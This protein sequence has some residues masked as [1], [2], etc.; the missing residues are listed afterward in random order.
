MTETISTF[1]RARGRSPS[2]PSAR[3]SIVREKI[4]THVLGMLTSLYIAAMEDRHHYG[5]KAAHLMGLDEINIPRVVDRAQVKKVINGHTSQEVLLRTLEDLVGKAE[6]QNLAPGERGPTYR[7]FQRHILHMLYGST[8]PYRQAARD[9]G[10]HPSTIHQAEISA[11]PDYAPPLPLE[12]RT[13]ER[14]FQHAERMSAQLGHRNLLAV[15]ESLYINTILQMHEESAIGKKSRQVL[16]H[17]IDILRDRQQ[18]LGS[19]YHIPKGKSVRQTLRSALE[20]F[21]D[22]KMLDELMPKHEKH[23]LTYRGFRYHL[24][25]ALHQV[26]GQLKTTARVLGTHVSCVDRVLEKEGNPELWHG[27]IPKAFITMREFTDLY[28]H[29]VAMGR[30]DTWVSK[31]LKC[32]GN[33]IPQRRER[34][35]VVLSQLQSCFG[36]FESWLRTVVPEPELLVQRKLSSRQAREYY[37]VSVCQLLGRDF[38]AAAYV[39][40]SRGHTLN[41]WYHKIQQKGV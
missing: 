32:R 4:G 10:E 38:A 25:H 2:G 28:T 21:G 18:M 19:V 34:G 31:K 6:A 14:I 9:F 13:Q 41:H 27:P 5:P 37:L 29:Y 39:L 30:T 20:G 12:L 40:G 33:F 15:C 36:G 11:V 16:R 26:Y 35:A 24:V 22:H 17:R 7:G 3:I 23:A 1:S 8:I